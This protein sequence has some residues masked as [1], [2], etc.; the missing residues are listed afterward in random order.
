MM[1]KNLVCLWYDGDPAATKRN[2]EI[3]AETE[4][5]FA[6]TTVRSADSDDRSRVPSTAAAG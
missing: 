1:A 2:R 3:R 6:D 5:L 4:A